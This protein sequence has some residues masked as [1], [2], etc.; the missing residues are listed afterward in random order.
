MKLKLIYNSNFK[1]Q[2]KMTKIVDNSVTSAMGGQYNLVLIAAA[3]ARELA[4]GAT[5]KVPKTSGNCVTALQEIE[6]GL[7]G[8]EYLLKS[9]ER[10][11][12]K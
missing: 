2:Q 9:V 11:K 12:K 8:K 1:E 4:R 7:I 6:A 5:P 3:R 10:K